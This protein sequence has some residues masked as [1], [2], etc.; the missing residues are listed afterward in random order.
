MD[1]GGVSVSRHTKHTENCLRESSFG[2][3]TV[4]NYQA[5][6]RKRTV[7]KAADIAG[8]VAAASSALAGLLLVFLGATQTAFEAYDKTAQKS[9]LSK[10]RRKA[11]L[12]FAGFVLSLIAL[13]LSLL[14]KRFENDCLVELSLISLLIGVVVVLSAAAASVWEIR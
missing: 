6:S 2:L 12:A 13:S 11:W 7:D 5:R 1:A 9:V 10:Y 8:D 4:S 14:G 3:I